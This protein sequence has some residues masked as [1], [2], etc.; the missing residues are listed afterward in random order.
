MALN[1]R[2]AVYLIALGAF[3]LGMAS[4][5]TAGLIP[6]IQTSF[7]VSAAIAAQ[8]VTAF[9]LAYGLGSPVFVALLPA[10]RQRSGL[11][12]SLGLFVIA[13]AASALSTDFT[14]LLIFRAIAGVGAGIYLAMGIA[15]AAA[16]SEPDQRG[17]AISVIMGGMASGTVLGVP[18]SLL[19]AERFGWAI[20]LWLVALLGA[21]AFIGLITKLP[22]L[23]I[24]QTISLK[25]KLM[26]LN[27]MHVVTILFVSLL[28]AIASLG[29]YT[30]IAPLLSDADYGAVH[31]ITPYLWVW[32]IGGV[33]GSFLIGPLVDRFQ[34]PV[35]SFSIM[36]I[37][38]ISLFLLSPTA[39]IGSWF[40]MIPIAVWG[41][42]GWALQVP[43]N[44][45]LIKARE[46]QGDGNLA[47]ALNESALYLG[48]AIGA[49]MGGILLLQ[50][51]SP[52]LL[53][54]IAGVVAGLG[55]F[56]QF[57]NIKKHSKLRQY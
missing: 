29:M 41:A 1:T 5:V 24:A 9:T 31:S 11:L 14:I 8:L 37:L 35:L 19:L 21:I 40:V 54:A 10:N 36:I 53:A 52:W 6:M 4:Y 18:L 51:L 49:A 3:A 15:A 33:I 45:E 13:N 2:S 7:S 34:G 22:M 27:D 25:Q 39:S 16:L 20:A 55:A 48:S 42:V 32:G 44:N 47:V 50:N 43:Q 57:V 30:F 23:P 56:I 12:F 38:A 28:A 26:L 17:K 46:L